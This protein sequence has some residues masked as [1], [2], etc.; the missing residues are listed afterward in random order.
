MI[1]HLSFLVFR[2]IFLYITNFYDTLYIFN[3]GFKNC[4]HFLI[5][6]TKWKKPCF[7]P[8]YLRKGTAKRYS[9]NFTTYSL[10]RWIFWVCFTVILSKPFN[11]KVKWRH[12]CEIINLK[13]WLK[14]I[15][16]HLMCTAIDVFKLMLSKNLFTFNLSLQRRWLCFN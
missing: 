14:L 3:D 2:F 6:L 11:C 7:M 12:C 5:Y 8:L 4:F 10:W 15:S 1:I 9:N 16:Y 13:S